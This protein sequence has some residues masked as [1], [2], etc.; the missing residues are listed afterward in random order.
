M[1]RLCYYL[2]RSPCPLAGE[3]GLHPAETLQWDLG[4]RPWTSA[5]N[6]S[7][8]VR[9]FRKGPMMYRSGESRPASALVPHE[10]MVRGL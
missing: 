5:V 4:W 2:G 3:A 9:L 8:C 10:P 6:C 1:K 7:G